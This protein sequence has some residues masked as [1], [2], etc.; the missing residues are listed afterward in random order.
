M[1]TFSS[2]KEVSDATSGGAASADLIDRLVWTSVFGKDAEVRGVARF[3]VRSLAAKAGIR[4]ASI[5]DLYI[6][7]G[8]GDGLLDIRSASV[9]NESFQAG[10][11]FVTSGTGGIFPPNIPVARVT[12]PSNDTALGSVFANPDALDFA[13]VLRSFMPEPPPAPKPSPTPT[14][15]ARS[16]AAP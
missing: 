1:T 16:K 7:M 5:H 11:A 14:P 4:P 10:D 15:P 13:L 6:A 3:T 2:V 12:K 8:R 9:A